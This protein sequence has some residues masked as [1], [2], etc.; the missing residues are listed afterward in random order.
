MP[1]PSRLACLAVAVV[2]L[3]PAAVFAEDAPDPADPAH[4]NCPEPDTGASTEAGGD[5]PAADDSGTECVTLVECD[6]DGA[7]VTFCAGCVDPEG[8]VSPCPSE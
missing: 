1:S 3:L 5:C 7:C 4:A 2:L 8:N 6:E